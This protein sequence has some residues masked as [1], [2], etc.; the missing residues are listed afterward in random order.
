MA[1]ADE[2]STVDNNIDTSGATSAEVGVELEVMGQ[3]GTDAKA[4][5]QNIELG[6]DE[7]DSGA[8]A[9][10]E[11]SSQGGEQETD[12]LVQRGQV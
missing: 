1:L 3:G 11:R 7:R 4:E 12:R 8:V 10:V 5:E 9:S 6:V 2:L